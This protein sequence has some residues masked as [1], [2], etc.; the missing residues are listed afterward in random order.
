MKQPKE[1]KNKLSDKNQSVSPFKITHKPANFIRRKTFFISLFVI[2]S[3]V[4]VSMVLLFIPWTKPWNWTGENQTAYDIEIDA[5]RE[6]QPGNRWVFFSEDFPKN[7][8]IN[9]GDHGYYAYGQKAE[10]LAKYIWDNGEK[11]KFDDRHRLKIY[12]IRYN[13][14]VGWGLLPAPELEV[15]DYQIKKLEP[16]PTPSP[17][18]EPT[19][20]PQ[21]PSNPPSE[22]GNGRINFSF[23]Q[24]LIMEQND[25]DSENTST[26]WHLKNYLKSLIVKRLQELQ[27]EFPEK[28][29]KFNGESETDAGSNNS[30]IELTTSQ[31]QFSTL[32][33]SQFSFSYLIIGEKETKT[34]PYTYRS[35]ILFYISTPKLIQKLP[36]FDPSDLNLKST[37]LAISDDFDSEIPD[38]YYLGARTLVQYFAS[39]FTKTS[40]SKTGLQNYYNLELI[41]SSDKSRSNGYKYLPKPNNPKYSDFTTVEFTEISVNVKI[42]VREQIVSQKKTVVLNSQDFFV[43]ITPKKLSEKLRDD[44]HEYPKHQ[45]DSTGIISKIGKKPKNN[46][47][48]IFLS[49][50]LLIGISLFLLWSRKS[51]KLNNLKCFRK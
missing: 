6:P 14:Y 3:L 12:S 32:N 17:G 28:E 8:S 5:G 46:L 16:K 43:V 38:S 9:Y 33:V 44:W 24:S 26:Y 23:P 10:E 7:R 48:Y 42:K 27:Q 51:L 30:H 2:V 41:S 13:Y 36:K 50:L 34:I 49:L 25:F 29:L 15:I 21:P 1:N 18:P 11:T 45:E 19:P 37:H 40:H 39:A 35:P 47:I 22:P 20:N 4:I 31:S